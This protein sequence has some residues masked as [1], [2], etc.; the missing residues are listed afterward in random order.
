MKA[1]SVS[2]LAHG[3]ASRAV[4]EAQDEPVLISKENR[5]AAWIV[6]TSDVARAAEARGVGLE[7]YQQAL[8]LIALDLYQREVFTLGQAAR[9]AGMT[10]GDFI[11]FCGA[12]HVPVLWEPKDGLQS[13]V[14]ALDAVLEYEEDSRA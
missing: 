11:D 4:R 7:I 2:D 3:G 14:D 8:E 1:I 13:D 5:P 9:L 6:S 10:L 12:L